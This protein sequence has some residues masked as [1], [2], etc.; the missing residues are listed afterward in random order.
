MKKLILLTATLLMGAF[1][2]F[3]QTEMSGEM[4]ELAK[5]KDGIRN[6]R[7]SSY[8]KGGYNRDHLEP[9]KPGGTAVLADIKG[10]GVINHIW[11]T[12]APGPERLSRNDIIH[13]T[14]WSPRCCP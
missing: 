5:I 12:I 1:G 13:K 10:A 14:K 2:A 3:A 8:D 7:V 11:I 9:I 6:R 4:F